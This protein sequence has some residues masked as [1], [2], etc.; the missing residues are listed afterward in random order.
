MAVYEPNVDLFLKVDDIFPAT[1]IDISKIIYT[2]INS[3][4]ELYNFLKLISENFNYIM[5][6]GNLRNLSGTAW[7]MNRQ[8]GEITWL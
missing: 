6:T 2:D 8:C 5:K 1:E 3:L 4:T 7:N